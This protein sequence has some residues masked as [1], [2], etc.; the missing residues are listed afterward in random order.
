ML[1]LGSMSKKFHRDLSK[2][3]N[4]SK[5][6]KVFIYGN[7]IKETFNH[8]SLKKKGKV[9]LFSDFFKINKLV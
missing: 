1:E 3:I 4:N 6:D 9:I 8:L 5:V 7:F 2:I